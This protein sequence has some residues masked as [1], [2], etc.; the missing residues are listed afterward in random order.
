MDV[1]GDDGVG[2]ARRDRLEEVA[3]I[4]DLLVEPCRLQRDGRP[5]REGFHH[6][7]FL[8]RELPAHRVAEGQGTDHPPLHDEG[9]G[10]HR[11]EA[12][13]LHSRLMVGRLRNPWIGQ[14]VRGDHG[15]ARARGEADGALPERVDEPASRA[16]AVITPEAQRF[17]IRRLRPQTEEGRVGHAEQGTHA[18]HDPIRHL[19]EVERLAEQATDLGVG[20]GGAPPPLRLLEEARVVDG[21][22]GLAREEAHQLP[23]LVGKAPMLA[24][25]DGEHP[26]RSIPGDQGQSR[27]RVEIGRLD[28]VPMDPARLVVDVLDEDGSA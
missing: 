28:E 16:H 6:L 4:A 24:E 9:H 19:G 7:H 18:L 5:V 3:R 17:E 14:Q 12:R 11:P 15:P 13:P 1:G 25:E 21:H 2:R 26:D 27:V 20:L 10:Q 22:R 8:V 23:L